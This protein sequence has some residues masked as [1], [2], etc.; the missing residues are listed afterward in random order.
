M[1]S[2]WSL[3][4]AHEV[5]EPKASK[6]GPAIDN[7]SPHTI[8]VR[9]ESVLNV[10]GETLSWT[11]EPGE[12]SLAAGQ[13]LPAICRPLDEASPFGSDYVESWFTYLTQL[14]TS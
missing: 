11:Y 9:A 12:L 14:L 6:K 2:Q 7:Q 5:T 4:P 3:R 8:D 13:Y 10:A 1:F